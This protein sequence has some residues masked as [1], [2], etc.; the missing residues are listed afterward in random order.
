VE[1]SPTGKWTWSGMREIKSKNKVNDDPNLQ[2]PDGVAVRYG[3]LNYSYQLEDM[4]IQHDVLSMYPVIFSSRP[5]LLLRTR[6]LELMVLIG[7][8]S[9][10]P[11]L[12]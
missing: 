12:C 5:V 3:S 8:M 6:I 10:C 7:G 4:V 1:E 2:L 11:V 9:T